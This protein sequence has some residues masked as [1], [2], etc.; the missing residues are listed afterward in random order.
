MVAVQAGVEVDLAS[1]GDLSSM[2]DE[3]VDKIVSALPRRKRKPLLRRIPQSAIAVANVPTILTFDAPPADYTYEITH[4]VVVGA[5]ASTVL[6][7]ATAAL[8]VGN[9]SVYS[10]GN[11]VQP[12]IVVPGYWNIGN[13]VIYAHFGDEVF[14]VVTGAATGANVSAVL[15][16]LQHT[17]DTIEAGGM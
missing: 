14:V 13:G 16:V 11:I 10:L 17:E 9:S 4:C 5:D 1:K 2:F 8:Y 6:A 7:G 15:S 12:G 3:G